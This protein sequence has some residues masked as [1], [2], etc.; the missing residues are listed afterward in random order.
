MDYWDW[1]DIVPESIHAGSLW[2]MTAYRISL[3]LADIG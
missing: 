2:K 3:F 1:V